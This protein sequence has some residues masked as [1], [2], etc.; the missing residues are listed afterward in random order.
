MNAKI[1]R[2]RRDGIEIAL[3]VATL[4]FGPGI[5]GDKPAPVYGL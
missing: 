3:R 4:M 2:I 1:L 5:C